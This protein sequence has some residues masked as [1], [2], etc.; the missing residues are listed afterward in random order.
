M[1]GSS[2]NFLT[3]PHNKPPY[4]ISIGIGAAY[5]MRPSW[6]LSCYKISGNKELCL[7][8]KGLRG[9]QNNYTYSHTHTQQEKDRT[10]L[11][12]PSLILQ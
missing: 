7:G 11:Q 4:W 3:N 1:K 2:G 12:I 10:Q 8:I 6:S 9:K 5:V